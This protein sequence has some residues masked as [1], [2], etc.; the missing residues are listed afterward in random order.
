MSDTNIDY[1]RITKDGLWDNNV[2][3]AQMLALCPTLA[4]T[5]EHDN[6]VEVFDVAS[7][8]L[9]LSLRNYLPAPALVEIGRLLVGGQRV[10]IVGD[11]AQ[12]HGWL[13]RCDPPRELTHRPHSRMRSVTRSP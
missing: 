8:K 2:V 4:V 3:F 13:R 6:I 5:F 7:G 12:G 9:E 1:A 10:V 11:Q